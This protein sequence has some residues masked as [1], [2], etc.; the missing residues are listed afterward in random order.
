[1]L[2]DARRNGLADQVGALEKNKKALAQEIDRLREKSVALGRGLS[3]TEAEHT[4]IAGLVKKGLSAAPRQLELEQNLAQLQSN[5]L[6]VEVAV[7]RAGEDIVR[8]ERDIADVKYRYNNELIQEAQDVRVKLAE[9][10]QK[11]D[12]ARQ[13]AHQ[14]ETIAP[15]QLQS[16]LDAARKPAYHIL[17]TDASGAHE[18]PAGETDEVRPG[19]VVRV[20]YEDPATI[21][22]A[23]R[24]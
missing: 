19:D 9:T 4:T 24:N 1:M 21:G 14:A 11:I 23:A 2:F 8:A 15:A 6:D 7:V 13:M 10:V 3:A 16:S 12:T 22:A 18:N 20:L 5:Q 17:R